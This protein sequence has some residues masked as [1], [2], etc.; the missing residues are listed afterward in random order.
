MNFE[1]YPWRYRCLRCGWIDSWSTENERDRWAAAHVLRHL[2]AGDFGESTGPSS[3]R[4]EKEQS[5]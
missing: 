1:R 5:E 2:V 4:A 3:V